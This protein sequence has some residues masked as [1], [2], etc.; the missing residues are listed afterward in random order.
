MRPPFDCFCDLMT[1]DDDEIDGEG[2]EI[3]KRNAVYVRTYMT[4][5]LRKK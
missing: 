3:S 2:G 4:V 5:G 1:N